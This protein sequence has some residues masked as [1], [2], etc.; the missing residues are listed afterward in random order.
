MTKQELIQIRNCLL[1]LN[2]TRAPYVGGI[3]ALPDHPA[4]GFAYNEALNSLTKAIAEMETIGDAKDHYH[5][6]TSWGYCLT[7]G[8]FESGKCY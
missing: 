3:V 8:R 5:H 1:V 7:C 6:I 4:L 2:E